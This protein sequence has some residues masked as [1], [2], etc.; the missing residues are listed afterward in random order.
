MTLNCDTAKA[1]VDEAHRA[2][3]AGDIDAVLRTYTDDIWFQRNSI[4]D[5]APPLIIRGREDMEKFLKSIAA[6]A[7]GMAVLTGFQFHCGIARTRVS[8]FLKGLEAAHN[9]SG[10][11]RQIIVFRGMQIARMEQFHDAPRLDAFFRLI[12]V[13]TFH[14]DPT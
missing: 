1:I 2:W 8:Y 14:E 3:S 13:P 11:Y 12:D 4:N 6:N 5:S 10:T 9:F 7:T